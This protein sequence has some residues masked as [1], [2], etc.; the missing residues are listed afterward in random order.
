LARRDLRI[1]ADVI[2]ESKRLLL[3][4]LG[5]MLGGGPTDKGRAV[6]QLAMDLSGARHATVIG[7]PNQVSVDHA[8]FANA[9]LANALDADAVFLNVAHLIP[10]VSAAALAVAEM[11]K[12][13]G[14]TVLEAVLVGNELASRLTLAMTPLLEGHDGTR[15]RFTIGPVFGYG[16]AALGAAAAAGRLL[17]LD[18]DRMAHALGL[19][20]YYCPVPSLLRW[21]R[22]RPFSMVKYSPMGWTAQAGVTA[23]LLAARG[24]T[25]DTGVLDDAEGLPRFWGTDRFQSKYLLEDLGRTWECIRWL[26]YK[27]EPVCNLFRPHLWLLSI[28]RQQEHLSADEIES[29]VLRIYGP[30]GADRPYSSDVPDTQEAVHMSGEFAIALALKGIP[31]GPKWVSPTLTRDPEMQR[32]MRKVRV[33]GN[34]STTHVAYRPWTGPSIADVLQSAP[35]AIEVR[36]RGRSF[37]RDT[38]TS[39]GD[40]WGPAVA[41]FTDSELVAKFAEMVSGRMSE[42]DRTQVSQCVLRDLDQLPTMEPLLQ[43]LRHKHKA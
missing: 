31:P 18:K 19:A 27:P 26:S 22:T 14:R 32:L 28:I 4:T 11:V 10:S 42:E 37:V 38:E 6:V 24:Y 34:P 9:E 15:A 39:H 2:Y 12:A 7:T 17:G 5:C 20:A 36:A 21:L 43:M 41:R 23:A 8:A 16:Y 29:V 35:S 25:G 33:E 40:M 13:G 30:A 3:D 1:A